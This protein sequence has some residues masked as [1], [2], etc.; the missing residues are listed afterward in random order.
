MDP[1]KIIGYPL[2]FIAASE[3]LLG[4]LLLKKNPSNNPV[5]KAVAVFSFSSAGYAL[6]AG[7]V[8]LRASM[9]LDYDL[10]YRA[11][12]IGWLTIPAAL[13]YVYYFNEKSRIASVEALILY[14]LW[15]LI[16]IL[17]LSTDLIERGAYSLFPFIDQRGVFE[18]PVRLFGAILLTWIVYE[19]FKL[20]KQSI[21]IKKMQLNYFLLGF[22]IFVGLG[23]AVVEIFQLFGGLGFDP[24]LGSYFGLPW[25]ALT[26][27]SITRYRLFDIRIVISNTFTVIFLLIGAII[28]HI[29]LFKLLE[30]FT[31]STLAIFISLSAVVLIIF[32]TPIR[33]V[34]QDVIN[35]IVLK[36]KYSY[37]E[38]LK[39]SIRAL[40]SKQNLDE[41]LNYIVEVIKKS[42]KVETVCLLMEDEDGFYRIRCSHGVNKKLADAYKI[43][44][45]VINWLRETKQV[46]IKE[47]QEIFRS[48]KDF[49]AIYGD[50]GLINAEI[51]TPIFRKE[52]LIGILTLGHKGNKNIYVQSDI[53]LLEALASQTAIAIENALLHEEAITDGLTGLYNYKYFESRLKEEIER[54]KRYKHPLSLLIIDFDHFKKVNDEYGH[55]IGDKALRR[56][57]RLWKKSIRAGDIV[58]RYG[59]E[60]FVVIL[61]ETSI[62]DAINVAE[63][64]RADVENMKI[65]EIA[66]TISIG[67]GYFGGEDLALDYKKLIRQADKALYKAKHKGRNRIESIA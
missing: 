56:S 48:Q 13:Q 19:L 45:G 1:L 8:Y 40:T 46:F 50:A 24:A 15:F 21:S 60:E 14:P 7:I 39:D 38:I 5:N 11:C 52:Q 22:L 59:G 3:I 49:S 37:Q 2:F 42:L 33:K 51:I 25:V 30:P 43:K 18:N 4:I 61:P 55:L 20:R 54:S 26:F 66:I 36:G 58:A 31:G 64:L 35:D 44:N 34:V 27:Y 57:A 16:F 12:W 65:D 67:I 47:E 32:K 6:F 53:A 29:G 41:L 28:I 63:K 9:G 62:S 17:C 23:G 10:F